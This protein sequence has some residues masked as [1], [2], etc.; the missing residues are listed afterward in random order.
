MQRPEN[1][2][3]AIP[4]L[5]AAAQQ[6]GQLIQALSEVLQANLELASTLIPSYARLLNA[7]DFENLSAQFP[8]IAPLLNGYRQLSPLAS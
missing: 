7:G 6:P 4:Y 1:F 3:E 2:S 5:N 8:S